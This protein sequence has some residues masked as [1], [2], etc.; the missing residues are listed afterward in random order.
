MLDHRCAFDRQQAFAD[1]YY[2][3][4]CLLFTRGELAHAAVDERARSGALPHPRP[5]GGRQAALARRIRCTD[6]LLVRDMTAP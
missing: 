5:R 4:A 2:N 6:P 3:R 1:P